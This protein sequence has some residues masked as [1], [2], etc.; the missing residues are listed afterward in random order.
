MAGYFENV[1]LKTME[2][3]HFIFRSMNISHDIYIEN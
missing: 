3:I 1:K 2:V